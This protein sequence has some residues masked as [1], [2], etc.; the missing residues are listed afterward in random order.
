MPVRVKPIRLSP[1]KCFHFPES[2]SN[3]WNIVT[4][5]T[6]NPQQEQ[7]AESRLVGSDRVLA[8]LI[9]LARHPAGIG[10]D[11][12]A[13]AVDSP[14]P[15]THRALASLRRAGLATQN[16]HGHYVLGDEFLRMAFAHHEAR[17][18]HVRVQPVLEALA[19]RFGET[20]HYAVLDGGS[21]V[22]RS[23]VDP[24]AGAVKL[25]STVGGRRPA[26][27]T[28]VGKLLLAY[29]LPDDAA[30]RD[31]VAGRE[32]A[33]LTEHTKTGADELCEEF[34]LIRQRGYSIED[35]E[36]EHGI[37]C[38]ALP[39]YLTSPTVPSGAISVSALLYRTSLQQLV[40]ELPAIRSAIDQRET[41]RSE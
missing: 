3:I 10:L 39:A 31:W 23:K 34:R 40:D 27:G 37:G 15:T 2:W 7:P 6:P 38:L 26:H 21:V 4:S 36:S 18:D 35:Q 17:P 8:V 11:D 12:M 41:E 1:C 22:Y 29:T 25:T 13:R 9:E 20:V 32:L 16:G 24:S 19:E 14:K 33:R 5:Q 30:V 28:A